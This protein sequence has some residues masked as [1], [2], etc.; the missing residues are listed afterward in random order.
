MCTF[1]ITDITNVSISHHSSRLFKQ[2]QQQP[3]WN[4]NEF[5]VLLII[6]KM[7]HEYE[8]WLSLKATKSYSKVGK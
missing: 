7:R 4:T 2:S 1:I 6:I 5:Q 3:A 8:S